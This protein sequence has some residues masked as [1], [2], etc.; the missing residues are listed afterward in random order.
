MRRHA[1]RTAARPHRSRPRPAGSRP[2]A[3]SRHRPNRGSGAAAIGCGAV[4]VRPDGVVAW[5][6]DHGPDPEAFERAADR[7]FGAPGR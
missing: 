2:R 5:A 7:W 6:D 3:G 1:A 4:L